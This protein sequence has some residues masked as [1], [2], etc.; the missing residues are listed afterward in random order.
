MR[1]GAVER[2]EGDWQPNI[3]VVE[4]ADAEAARRWYRSPA[5]ALALDMHDKVLFRNLIP[6]E[7]VAA[8]CSEAT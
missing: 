1:G 6:V 4:F 5:Y 3:V 7:G 2:L 8:P